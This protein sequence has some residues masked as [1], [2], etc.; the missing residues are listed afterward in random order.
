MTRL[1]AARLFQDE[2]RAQMPGNW[3][4]GIDL[5]D[6]ANAVFIF[7]LIIREET[8]KQKEAIENV[9]LG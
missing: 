8:K 7:E 3:P 1:A 5:I 6:A 9:P 4:D 2:A